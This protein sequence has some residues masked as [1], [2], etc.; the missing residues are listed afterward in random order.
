ML[1]YNRTFKVFDDDGSRS[2]DF[3]E[4]KKGL[5][6]YGIHL[7]PQ[8]SIYLFKLNRKHETWYM[9]CGS[10]FVLSEAKQSAPLH[11]KRSQILINR[12]WKSNID[13]GI[14][15]LILM[16]AKLD[17]NSFHCIFLIFTVLNSHFNKNNTKTPQRGSQR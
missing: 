4:F 6:D 14:L 9:N 3:N 13:F 15:N 11:Q 12:I 1:F 17:F 16:D 2:L 5:R 10:L 7:E 8:V